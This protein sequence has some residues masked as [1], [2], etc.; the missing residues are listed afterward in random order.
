MSCCF[1]NY[2][3]WQFTSTSFSNWGCNITSTWD[4]HRLVNVGAPWQWV[5]NG[6]TD[7][8][9]RSTK[10]FNLSWVVVG[11]VLE[12]EKPWFFDTI[13]IYFNF[14]RAGIDFIRHFHVIQT[15][16]S[17]LIT[18]KNSRHI[19]QGLRFLCTSQLITHGNILVISRLQLFFKFR[20]WEVDV[21]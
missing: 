18:T 15:T 20:S 7:T 12:H 21:F 11:F 17:T 1:R 13:D 8:S 4:T 6:T 14:N 19:H 5:T 16:I 3:L 9:S 10:W 2:L